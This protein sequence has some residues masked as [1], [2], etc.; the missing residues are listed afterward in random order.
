[1]RVIQWRRGGTT[2]RAPPTPGAQPQFAGEDAT[3]YALQVARINAPWTTGRKLFFIENTIFVACMIGGLI[4]LFTG[5]KVSRALA[6]AIFILVVML[7]HAVLRQ[8]YFKQVIPEIQSHRQTN[9][10]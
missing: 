9:S 8:T 5:H 6:A 7:I 3:E 2:G 1:M 4:Y 10:E